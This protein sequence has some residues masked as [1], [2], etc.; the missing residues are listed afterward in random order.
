MFSKSTPILGNC[1]DCTPSAA[2]TRCTSAESLIGCSPFSRFQD[3]SKRRRA[4]SKAALASAV[5]RPAA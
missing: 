4:S 1:K 3:A 2:V 5:H